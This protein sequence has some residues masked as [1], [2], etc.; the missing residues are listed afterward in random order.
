MDP[1]SF[2]KI[3]YGVYIISSKRGGRF[4]GQVA[5]AMMQVTSDPPQIALALNKNNL[6]HEFIKDSGVFTLSILSQDAPLNLIGGFGFKSGRDVDKF[7]DTPY[8]L[9][10]NGCPYLAENAL[11]YLEGKIVKDVDVGTH[12]IFVAVI[13]DA[14][15]LR[16]GEPMTYAY[17]HQTKRGTTP[18]TAPTYVE[19]KKE[20]R[21]MKKYTCKVCG[22]EYDP[23]QGDPEAGVAPNTPFE[24]LPADWVCPVCG[25]GKDQFEAQG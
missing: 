22:Y 11:C 25:A 23:S 8:R 24:K 5:N 2:F 1:K 17:Y 16:E 9:G 14:E 10:R 6:T 18:K 4:N 21:A 15:V 3:S 7:A 19:I 13:T 20:E 12:T